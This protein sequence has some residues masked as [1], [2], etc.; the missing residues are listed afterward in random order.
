MTVYPTSLQIVDEQLQIGWSDGQVR[1]YAFG[2]LRGN[3]PCAGCR[4]QRR[5]HQHLPTRCT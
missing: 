1:R 3:C 2:E 5:S 4:E